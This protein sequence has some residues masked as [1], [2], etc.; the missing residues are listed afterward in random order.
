MLV[1]HGLE[2]T[3]KSCTIKA[4]LEALGAL[5]V[6]VHSQECITSRHLLERTFAA[7]IGAFK[8]HDDTLPL[9]S[10]DTKCENVSALI[11]QLRQLLE[12]VEKFIIVFDGID[13]QREA[14]STLLPALAR[15]GEIVCAYTVM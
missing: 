12:N 10:L 6:I 4:V 15:M 7:C 3:G 11:V 2:A 8:K 5:H 13:R 1:L 9:E 14:P